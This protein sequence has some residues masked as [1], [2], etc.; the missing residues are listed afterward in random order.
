VEDWK[1]STN[2]TNKKDSIV[3]QEDT[4]EDIARNKE[5]NYNK[6]KHK[7]K[8]N[9]GTRFAR[10]GEISRWFQ[11]ICWMRIPVIG[12]LYMLVLLIRK[13]TPEYKKD[14]IIGYFIYKVLVWL[15]AIILIYGLYKTGINFID[16]ILQYVS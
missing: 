13:S 6:K 4:K 9:A 14:F 2:G 1:D 5:N 16:S 10:S 11:T 3:Y 12:V 7:K 8:K 15:L